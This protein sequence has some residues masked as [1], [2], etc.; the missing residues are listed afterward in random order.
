MLNTENSTVKGELQ[1]KIGKAHSTQKIPELLKSCYTVD[2]EKKTY[3]FDPSQLISVDV[4]QDFWKI[5]FRKEFPVLGILVRQV[6]A[7]V[8]VSVKCESTFRK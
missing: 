7:A 5:V 2:E 8:Q 3:S 1:S 6:F 4:L